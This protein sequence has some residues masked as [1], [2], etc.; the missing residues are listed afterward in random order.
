MAKCVW[1]LI[2]VLS[3][4]KIQRTLSF[5]EVHMDS[6]LCSVSGTTD[7]IVNALFYN[8]FRLPRVV[9]FNRNISPFCL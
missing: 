1:L 4:V 3:C 8:I 5:P 9:I 7:N 6:L 2:L